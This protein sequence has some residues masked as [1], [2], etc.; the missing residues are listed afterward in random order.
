[1]DDGLICDTGG[2]FSLYDTDD[3]NH[4]AVKAVVVAVG[5]GINRWRSSPLVRCRQT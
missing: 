5:G 3:T 2:V 1:M 4:L